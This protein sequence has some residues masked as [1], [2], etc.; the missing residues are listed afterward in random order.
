MSS[1]VVFTDTAS[2]DLLDIATR[3]ADISGSKNVAIRFVKELRERIEVLERFPESGAVPRDRVLRCNGYRFLVYKDYLM[4]YT[5]NKD[6]DTVYITAVFN[7]KRDY[8]RVMK[9]YL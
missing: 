4:F 6:I 8:M 3:I 2:L 1:R 7:G 5:Y 9:K